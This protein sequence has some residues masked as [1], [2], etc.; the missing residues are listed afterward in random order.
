MKVELQNLVLSILDDPLVSRVFGEAGFRSCDIKMATLMPGK[1]FHPS[2]LF[3][4][5]S[6]YKRPSP[7]LFLC[8]FSDGYSGVGGKGFSFP[9]M[10]CFSGDDENSR[11]IGEIMLRDK[12]RSP[13]LLGVS[14][15]G[16]LSSFLKLLQRKSNF[17]L[18]DGLS[19]LSVVCVKDEI[20]MYLSGDSD[21]TPLKS[22]FEEVEKMLSENAKIVV[23]FGD[24]QVLA[25]DGVGIDRL[26]Y[27]VRNLARLIEVYVGKVWLIGEATTYDVYVKILNKFPTI[28][29]DWDLEILPITSVGSSYPRSR[30]LSILEIA[31]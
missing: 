23:N 2:R 19:G 24:L 27:L 7:P 3:G 29:Q 5:T 16:A 20:L 1:S 25:G 14:A 9:F 30:Y 15:G 10:G 4:C 21:E 18:P 6:R 17:V 11:R 8:N 28:E 22:R 31:Y 13:L 26:R 12:K